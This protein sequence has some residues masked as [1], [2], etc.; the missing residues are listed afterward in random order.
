MRILGRAE[1]KCGTALGEGS[2]ASRSHERWRFCIG[3][4]SR[5]GL[6]T[7]SLRGPSRPAEAR[8]VFMV[9][10]GALPALGSESQRLEVNLARRFR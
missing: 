3:R 5:C 6:R 7:V 9:H 8:I 2:R 10:L 1:Y 4:G